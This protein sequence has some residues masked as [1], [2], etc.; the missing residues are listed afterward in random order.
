MGGWMNEKKYQH[1]NTK[2]IFKDDGL[3]V[4]KDIY[5]YNCYK[6]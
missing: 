5:F 2:V 4:N 1:L 6:N 3:W